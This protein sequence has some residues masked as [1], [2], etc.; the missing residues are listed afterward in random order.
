M[1]IYQLSQRGIITRGELI[2]HVLVNRPGR[3]PDNCLEI[4]RQRLKGLLVYNKFQR[5]ARLVPT[6]I[7]IVLGHLMKTK[8]QVIIGAHPFQGIDNPGFFL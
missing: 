6:R 3:V 8:G 5:G 1:H 2:Q 4:G 7:I